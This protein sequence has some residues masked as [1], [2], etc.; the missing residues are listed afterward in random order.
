M[1]EGPSD[2]RTTTTAATCERTNTFL[3]VC[4]PLPLMIQLHNSLSDFCP[5]LKIPRA[6]DD[7]NDISNH[8]RISCGHSAALT[9]VLSLDRDLRRDIPIEGF[10]DCWAGPNPNVGGGSR[11][12]LPK[13]EIT[14]PVMKGDRRARGF[15]DIFDGTIKSLRTGPI[16]ICIYAIDA[17]PLNLPRTH[18]TV[19]TRSCT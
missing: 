16:Y 8:L 14:R 17:D 3:P 18:V 2:M 9:V 15:P 10:W 6:K 12:D 7:D 5:L 19:W 11:R 1:L 13:K 4:R